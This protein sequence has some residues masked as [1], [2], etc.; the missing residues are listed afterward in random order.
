MSHISL[1]L[2]IHNNNNGR[3]L[4]ETLSILIKVNL[5]TDGLSKEYQLTLYADDTTLNSDGIEVSLKYN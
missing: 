5:N 4:P 1:T 3:K 2:S